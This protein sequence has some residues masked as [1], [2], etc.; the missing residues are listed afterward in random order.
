MNAQ[1]Q[2]SSLG[3]VFS[4]CTTYMCNLRCPY[5]F[6]GHDIHKINHS[7]SQE[8]MDNMFFAIDRIL[9]TEKARGRFQNAQHT[10]L[11][12]GGEPLLPT[13]KKTVHEVVRR[14]IEEYGF[15]SYAI[16]NGTFLHEFLDFFEQY[17][18]MWDFFQISIDGPKH[19]HDQRR[20]TAGGQGTFDKIVSNIDLA[21]T[22][23]FKIALRAKYK[24]LRK[25]LQMRQTASSRRRLK[26][27]GQR[28]NRWMTDV[29]HTVSKALVEGYGAKTLFVVEDLT[30]VR[31]ATERVRVKNR[32]EYVS[33]AF[34][35]LRQMI[36]YK[37]LMHQSKVMAVD[38]RY[39]SQ[40]CPKCGHTK[41]ANRNKKM[42]VFCCKACH[43]TSNDDRIG[44]M[45]LQRKGIEYIVEVTTG[46]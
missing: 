21:L 1:L 23:G 33:W 38:P 2:A 43:Y 26:K 5:C 45:N 14:G 46:A 4:V 32:Y 30:G 24:H 29:N 36:E 18:S 16:T 27:I 22:R 17:K 13:S 34:Y 35:Q 39:T 3:V 15:R 41:K 31:N 19:I 42:H 10:M 11:L 20:V 28:E 7:L 6:Q 25:Q 12:Y 44:A 40:T 8:E 9:E 37:A